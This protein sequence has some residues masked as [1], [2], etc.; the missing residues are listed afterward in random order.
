MHDFG[1][2]EFQLWD[3]W[4]SHSQL[5][6]RSPLN[7]NEGVMT[8][9]DIIFR[10]VDYLAL[11][12]GPFKLRLCEAS[13]EESALAL[14]ESKPGAISPGGNVF[15]LFCE[16]SKHYVIAYSFEVSENTLELFES[17]LIRDWSKLT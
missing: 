15:V 2:R 5:L 10:G 12:S 8:N 3:Y 14:S 11:P 7:E 1:D 9:L 17:S 6:I 13:D 16:G 4:V